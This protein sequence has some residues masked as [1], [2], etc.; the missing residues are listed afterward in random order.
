MTLTI[1]TTEKDSSAVI[2]EQPLLATLH[3][4]T[5]LNE[6]DEIQVNTGPGVRFTKTRMGVVFANALG[7]SLSAPVNKQLFVKPKY[8]KKP[9]ITKK[10]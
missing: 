9:T 5:N 1:D 6:I 3:N 8:H 7:F 4:L 2:T 10:P